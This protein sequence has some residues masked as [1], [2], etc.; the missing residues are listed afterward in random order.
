MPQ[1]W[2]DMKGNLLVHCL[3][4]TDPKYTTIAT[5][6]TASAGL[7]FTIQKIEVV[8]NKSLWQ[9]Y[10]AKKKQLEE[11]N[12]QGTTNERFLWFGTSA[13]TV[14]SVN[15]HGFNR[16]YC[17][18]N[19]VVF[20]D[21]VYFAVNASY[22]ASDTYSIP[23]PNGVKRMYYCGVLTGEYAMGKAGMRV[24]PPKPSGGKNALFDSVTDNLQN[25]G[26]F[27]IFNDTQAYPL[28]IVHFR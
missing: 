5:T 25:P 1:D 21:G 4:S 27:I 26:M 19:A 18:K 15:A 24:T 28:Y 6:F 12:P 13:D 7:N 20:G 22:A 14:D 10:A 17:G 2:K 23:D 9:Q 8:Q 11:Q 16:S 3:L